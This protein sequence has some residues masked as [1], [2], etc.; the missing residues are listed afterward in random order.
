MKIFVFDPLWDTLITDELLDLFNK[1]DVELIV[2][3]EV[4]P[5]SDCHE[6]F[7]GTEDRILC[8]NPDYVNWV[9]NSD[10]YKDIP[11]LRAI[12]LSIT[13][14]SWV[15]T[16]YADQNGIAV[17]NIRNFS[18]E[19]AAEWAI[20]MMFCVARQVPRLMK[21]SF[22]LD[23]D[24]DFMRYRGI[25][26]HGKTAGII[27]L[28]NN[29]TAIAKRCSG[30]GMKVVYWSRSSTNDDYEKVTLSEL[31]STADVVF[32]TFAKNKES[33][34]LITN[35]L[36][37]LLKPSAILIDTIELEQTKNTILKMVKNGDLFG[38][39]LEAKPGTF[40]DYIGNVWAAPAYAWVTNESMN[41]TMQKWI[42]NMVDAVNEEFPNRIN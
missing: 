7:T 16:S 6:L 3:K 19:A 34:A 39:G 14:F 11:G 22:P 28:G 42:H 13:S 36:L 2:K 32:P 41:N 26:L 40:N 23:F 35:E 24:K 1:V 29:G 20:M 27:G 18:T 10:D 9:L 21:D 33:N 38:Y 15:D 17:C 30:L 4:A 31:F 12:L 8:I 25:E 37:A 5:L